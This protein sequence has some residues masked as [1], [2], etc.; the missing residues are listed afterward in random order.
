MVQMAGFHS[1]KQHILNI[2]PAL[3]LGAM[4]RDEQ[5]IIPDLKE[6]SD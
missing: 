6:L 3:V 4:D 5:D 2:L 1:F